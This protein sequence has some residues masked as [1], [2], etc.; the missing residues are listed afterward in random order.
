MRVGEGRCSDVNNGMRARFSVASPQPSLSRQDPKQQ[1]RITSSWAAHIHRL[2]SLGLGFVIFDF[3]VYFP[4]TALIAVV[5]NDVIDCDHSGKHRVVLI[6]V[7]MHSISA[8]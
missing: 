6:V 8:N 3:G 4:N 2:W 7:L 5:S 1:R